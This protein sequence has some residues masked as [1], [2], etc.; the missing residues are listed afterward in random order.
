[1]SV[2]LWSLFAATQEQ[3][4]KHSLVLVFKVLRTSKNTTVVLRRPSLC[5]IDSVVLLKIG[6]SQFPLIILFSRQRSL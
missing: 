1:M 6:K 2:F 3:T 5:W 4:K